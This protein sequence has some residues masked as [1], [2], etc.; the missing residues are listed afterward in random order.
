[1]NFYRNLSGQALRFGIVGLTS[2]VVLYLLYLLLTTI[3][4]GHKTAMTLLFAVGTLQTFMFNRRWTF[5]HQ[6]LLHSSFV[7]Y[8]LIYGLAYLLN[9]T[10]LLLLVDHLGFPHQIVQGVMILVLALMLFLLQRYWVF[11]ASEPA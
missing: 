5:G 8:I 9:L 6:G 10:A 11:R 7:K 2:N 1:M 3:G 4:I